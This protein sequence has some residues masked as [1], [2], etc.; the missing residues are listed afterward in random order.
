MHAR[1][2]ELLEHLSS[3]RQSLADAYLA[4][5]AGDRDRRPR[6]EAWSPGEVLCHLAMIEKSVVAILRR[7]LQRAVGAGSL[8]LAQQGPR[9]WRDLA[10]LLLDDGTKIDAPSFVVP[11]GTM[12]AAEAWQSLQ[13]SR[14]ALRDVLLAA[15]GLDTSSIVQRHVVLGPMTFE[16]WLGF[17][18]FHEQRHAGQIARG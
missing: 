17:V 16:Q 1:T 10:T 8:P 5:A 4:V 13:D 7:K 18:G 2:E 11:D 15:D 3:T 14:T 6:P 9:T 12:Q